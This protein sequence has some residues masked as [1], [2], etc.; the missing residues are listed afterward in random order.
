MESEGKADNLMVSE[1]TKLILEKDESNPYEF[2]SPK[3]VKF[4]DTESI[5]AFLV[6]ERIMNSD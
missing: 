4:N 2:H 6:K 1:A 5:Q 3:E